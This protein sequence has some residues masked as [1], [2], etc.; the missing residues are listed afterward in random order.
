MFGAEGVRVPYEADVSFWLYCSVS[1]I[2][3]GEAQAIVGEI[4]DLSRVKNDSLSITGA[5]IFTGTHF[6][7][8]IEG[9]SEEI[10]TLRSSITGD[11]RHGDILTIDDG[12]CAAR[13]F[14]GW[15]LAYAGD[16]AYFSQLIA[17]SRERQ[18]S[19]A[20]TLLLEM[21]RRFIS[22]A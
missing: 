14:V 13:L 7:Q 17:W 5:L 1:T 4:V 15:S 18:R 8:Y 10:A 6:A 21:M 12:R 16:M 9:P 2:A 3:A 19:S 22:D 20:R 11:F